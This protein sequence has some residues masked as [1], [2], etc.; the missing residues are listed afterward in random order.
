VIFYFSFQS[1]LFLYDFNLYHFILFI[2]SNKNISI[3]EKHFTLFLN[4]LYLIFII[5]KMINALS[6]YYSEQE[7]GIIH[8]LEFE[9]QMINIISLHSQIYIDTLLSTNQ[10]ELSI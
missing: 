8:S 10:Y 5:L 7:V 9:A 4:L 1:F 6:T 2:I 3:I